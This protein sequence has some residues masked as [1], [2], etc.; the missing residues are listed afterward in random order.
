MMT[1]QYETLFEAIL[2]LQEKGYTHNFKINNKGL[3]HE[4]DGKKFSVNEVQLN[5]FHRFKE[6]NSL[7]DSSILYALETSEGVK[8]TVATECGT[9]NSEVIAKFMNNVE[10]REN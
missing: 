9:D 6:I 3:L 10:H 1:N 4:I 2:G 7:S 8:G 5:E